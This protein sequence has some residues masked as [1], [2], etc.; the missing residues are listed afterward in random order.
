MMNLAFEPVTPL[1]TT[2]S[3]QYSACKE[4]NKAADMVNFVNVIWNCITNGRI[5]LDSS[6]FKFG[7]ES[8]GKSSPGVS[9]PSSGSLWLFLDIFGDGWCRVAALS[10]SDSP[11]ATTVLL[12]WRFRTPRN[13]CRVDESSLVPLVTMLWRST[14]CWGISTWN[15]FVKLIVAFLGL[16]RNLSTA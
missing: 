7:V 11:P 1:E 15:Q 8:G 14:G 16:F 6:A 5:K 2:F 10:A 3:I 4:G 13:S 9:R 12:L